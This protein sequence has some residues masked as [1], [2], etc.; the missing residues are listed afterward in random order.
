ML[1]TLFHAFKQLSHTLVWLVVSLMWA[2][3][4][5]AQTQLLG[6]ATP[7]NTVKTPQVQATLLADA[8]Q[9]GISGWVAPEGAV[10]SDGGDSDDWADFS[11][12]SEKAVKSGSAAGRFL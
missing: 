8:P 4:A 6:S 2:V 7:H 1:L 11:D 10:W 3:T 9:G 12:F 5:H